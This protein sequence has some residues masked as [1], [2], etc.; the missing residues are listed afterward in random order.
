M[1][2][3]LLMFESCGPRCSVAVADEN[4]PLLDWTSDLG[5]AVAGP[6]LD[7]AKSLLVA[8]DW[9]MDDIDVF[10]ACLGP[11]SFTGIKIAVT[12]A[13]TM[14]HALDRPVV[15]VGA[16]EALAAEVRTTDR[17]VAFVPSRRGWVFM[18]R[19]QGSTPLDEGRA[20]PIEEVP[21]ELLAWATEPALIAGPVEFDN[22]PPNFSHAVY[23]YPS[24]SIAAR[25]AVQRV[26]DGKTM[27]PM[28]LAPIYLAAPSV[29]KPKRQFGPG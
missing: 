1:T 25:L 27:S 13:K 19:F 21:N 2:L 15:G 4:G 6:M 7:A 28:E 9:T 18:Q 23:Q 10:G 12:L 11:G 14:A 3:R 16:L 26:R 17:V 8:V 5:N 24:A 22:L 20:L 29:T